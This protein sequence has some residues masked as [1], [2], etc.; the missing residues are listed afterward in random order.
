MLMDGKSQIF[1]EKTYLEDGYYLMDLSL[2]DIMMDG[3]PIQT[4]PLEDMA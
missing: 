2:M 1:E 3:I 4:V